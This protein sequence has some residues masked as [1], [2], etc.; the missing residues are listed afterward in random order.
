ML[1]VGVTAVLGATVYKATE[2]ISEGLPDGV[3]GPMIAGTIAAAVAGYAAIAWLLA[4]V[5]T[6]SYAPFVWYR[7]AVAAAC[8]LLIAAGVREATF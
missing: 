8:L 1:L 3:A 2:A 7:F 6:H 4:I 5:R